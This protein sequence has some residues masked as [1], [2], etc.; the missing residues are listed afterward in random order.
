MQ[1]D[2]C[3]VRV[4]PIEKP[5]V[6]IGDRIATCIACFLVGAIA[7]ERREKF[8][9]GIPVGEQQI[10]VVALHWRALD[11]RN[12]I[13]VSEHEHGDFRESPARAG[14]KQL[15]CQRAKLG[16]PASVQSSTPV[17][18]LERNREKSRCSPRT[19]CL[20]RASSAGC[21]T[22]LALRRRCTGVTQFT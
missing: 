9:R 22:M 17:G 16:R 15:L 1:S 7:S 12:V 5:I 11:L 6:I 10:V 14:S 18:A 13:A 3:R 2:M 8:E 4:N 21:R 20:P 19:G